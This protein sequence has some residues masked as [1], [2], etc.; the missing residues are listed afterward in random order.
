MVVGARDVTDVKAGELGVPE[1][2]EEGGVARPHVQALEGF[3]GLASG[4]LIVLGPNSLDKTFDCNSGND[5]CVEM[6]L[7]VKE[8]L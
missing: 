8:R 1:H 5:M 7:L 6:V 2:L 3:P 4:S